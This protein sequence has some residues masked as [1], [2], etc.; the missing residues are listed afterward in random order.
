MLPEGRYRA[1]AIKGEIG[2]GKSAEQI[3]IEF[4]LTEAG[5]FKGSHRTYYGS[6][7]EAALEITIKAMRTA[8][9]R[10]DDVAD[11]SSLSRADTP[12]VE[13]V[14]AHEEWEGKTRE[15][16]KWVNSAGGVALK[17]LDQGK[18]QE[19]AARIRKT[20][21]AVDQDLKSSGKNGG[22]AP[23]GDIPF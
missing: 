13:L 16:I 3:G 11:L 1:K 14:V 4:V 20:V 7:S 22:P 18:K 5:E 19:L 17:A 8:G 15:K 10:G 12:E 6:F 23:A 21:A 2:E 9:W